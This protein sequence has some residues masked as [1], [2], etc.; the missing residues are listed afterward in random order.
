MVGRV[1]VI[2]LGP[3]DPSLLSAAALSA[4]DRISERY[5][6]TARHP[7]AAGARSRHHL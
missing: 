6:R 7:S 1:V 4:I 5:L 3:G 2:G